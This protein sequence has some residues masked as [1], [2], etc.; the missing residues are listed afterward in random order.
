[1]GKNRQDVAENLKWKLDDI[2][3]NTDEWNRAYDEVST[4]LDFSK[5]EGQVSI[6]GEF[7]RLVK[8]DSALTEEEKNEVLKVGLKALS[9]ERV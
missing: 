5:Y 8:R 2:F 6:E 7:V 3:A 1:M 4:M 9:G